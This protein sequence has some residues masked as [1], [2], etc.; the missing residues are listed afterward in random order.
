MSQSK[1][2]RAWSSLPE[3]RFESYGVMRRALRVAGVDYDA[4]MMSESF[5]EGKIDGGTD[6]YRQG[7]YG[8]GTDLE[9]RVKEKLGASVFLSGKELSLG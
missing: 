9:R 4:L 2:K 7:H 5:G 8:D 1:M 6:E 3:I